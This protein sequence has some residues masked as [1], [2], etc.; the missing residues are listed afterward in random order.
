MNVKG[1][2]IFKFLSPLCLSKLKNYSRHDNIKITFW[3]LDCGLINAWLAKNAA[4]CW[5]VCMRDLCY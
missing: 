5:S 3:L 2:I 1:M 4:M